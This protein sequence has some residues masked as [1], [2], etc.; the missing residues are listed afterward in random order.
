VLGLE[1]NIL[2]TIENKEETYLLWEAKTKYSVNQEEELTVVLTNLIESIDNLPYYSSSNSY[3]S[4]S[5]QDENYYSFP[6]LTN[7][8]SNNE[9]TAIIPQPRRNLFLVKKRTPIKK[10]LA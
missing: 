3:S 10:Y 5:E 7:L 2:Q 8:R 9:L 6:A 4:L 1:K